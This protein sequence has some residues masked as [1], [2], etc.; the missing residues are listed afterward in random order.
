[1]M[2]IVICY[3]RPNV[4]LYTVHSQGHS[5]LQPSLT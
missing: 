1:L 5:E 2:H 3:L 4:M